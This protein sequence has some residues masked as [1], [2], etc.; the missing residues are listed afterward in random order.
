MYKVNI[1]IIYT[2]IIIKKKEKHILKM[3]K[4]H[5]KNMPEFLKW[6]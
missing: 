2:Q 4:K 3:I 5:L 6:L 1:K